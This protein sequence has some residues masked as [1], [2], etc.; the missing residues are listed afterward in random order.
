[1]PHHNPLDHPTATDE[2]FTITVSL[3]WRLHDEA[4]SQG[5]PWAQPDLV[6]AI[7]ELELGPWQPVGSGAVLDD[8]PYTIACSLLDQMLVELGRVT[9][10]LGARIAVAKTQSW[11]DPDGA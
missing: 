2:L 7:G 8:L 6:V 9:P 4:A 5:V 1:M 11:L 10:G 3:M